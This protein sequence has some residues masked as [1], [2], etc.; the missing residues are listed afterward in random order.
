MNEEASSSLAVDFVA[1]PKVGHGRTQRGPCFDPDLFGQRFIGLAVRGRHV[2]PWRIGLQRRRIEDAPHEP[3]GIDR[4]HLIVSVHEIIVQQFRI[5]IW[6][7]RV[8]ALMR[9]WPRL[10]GLRLQIPPVD[11][12]PRESSSC[13]TICTLAR[14]WA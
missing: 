11:R 10:R 9:T 2:V 3:N 8:I 5:D 13:A 14:I 7:S 6:V 1:G 12:V 4:H